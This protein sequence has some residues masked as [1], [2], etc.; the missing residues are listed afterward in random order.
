V[1]GRKAKFNLIPKDAF[2]K[3]LTPVPG[4]F[5][6]T[7]L[8]EMFDFFNTNGFGEAGK[9]EVLSNTKEVFSCGFPIYDCVA[10]GSSQ[11]LE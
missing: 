6:A 10:W 4:A 11:Y 7:D 5:V 8:W 2:I 1:T 9:P 3:M